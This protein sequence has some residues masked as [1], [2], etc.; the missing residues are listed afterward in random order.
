MVEGKTPMDTSMGVLILR[1]EIVNTVRF[2][3]PFLAERRYPDCEE[4]TV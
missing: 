2:C 1:N 4:V 3:E